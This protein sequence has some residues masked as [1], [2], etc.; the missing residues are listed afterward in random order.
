MPKV[1]FML[2]HLALVE[3]N[4]PHHGRQSFVAAPSWYI[5]QSLVQP[6]TYDDI[7]KNEC[8]F[9][10]LYQQ[11]ISKSLKTQ[12]YWGLDQTQYSH[13]LKQLGSVSLEL[14]EWHKENDGRSFTGITET[15]MY[16]ES[17]KDELFPRKSTILVCYS[18]SSPKSC[19]NL[20]T[21]NYLRH[22]S[23]INQQDIHW[24]QRE[25]QG[26]WL[27]WVF[28]LAWHTTC[29]DHWAIQSTSHRCLTNRNGPGIVR[30]PEFQRAPS[31]LSSPSGVYHSDQH[32]CPHHCFW[33]LICVLWWNV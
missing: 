31:S 25:R 7:L 9:S 32:C 28:G 30:N 11:I 17:I 19:S 26:W 15:T 1:D 13:F 20:I 4:G 16:L 27:A 14:A 22:Q 5:S 33:A 8:H 23:I 3:V 18:N 21:A 24:V 2:D 6:H 10:I 12:H 29:N